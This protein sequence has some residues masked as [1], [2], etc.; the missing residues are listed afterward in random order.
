MTDLID[1]DLEA[2]RSVI[3]SAQILFPTNSSTAVPEQ[4][5]V[6]AL[7]AGR[8]R[9]WIDAA[10]TIGRTPSLYVTAYTDPTGSEARNVNLRHERAAYVANLLAGR[11]IDR[12]YLSLREGK[13]ADLT[14]DAVH[15]RRVTILTHL[16]QGR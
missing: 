8:A 7:A 9:E 14:A 6:V 16:D 12:K 15:S 13:P 11:G 1:T 4:A 10:Q 5:R 3:E 2:L